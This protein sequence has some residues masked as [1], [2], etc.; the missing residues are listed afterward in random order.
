MF[1]DFTTTARNAP[2]LPELQLAVAATYEQEK[3]WA[4]AIAQYDNWLA[5]NPKHALL[6]RAEY[7]RAWDTAQAGLK[8]NALAAF[9]RF[10]ADFQT[11]EYAPLAQWWVASYYYSAGEMTEAERNYK[12][13]FQ[14]TNWPPS[15]LAYQSRMMA[16]RAAVRRQGWNQV[17]DY[18]PGL[19]NNT[20][21]PSP[22]LREQALFEYGQSLMQWT[23][24]GETNKLANCEEATRCFG[25]VCDEY[26]TN[27]LAVRAWIEKA[28]C[29][30]Q[31]ALARQNYDSLTNA[32]NAYQ[33]AFDSPQADVDLRSE[34]KLGQAI[35]LGKW[36]DQ[37]TG[38]ARTALLKQALSNCLDVVYVGDGE[39]L[40]PSLRQKAA[41]KAFD[42]ADALQAWSQAVNI[43]MRLTNSVWPLTDPSMQ[44]RVTNAF[45]NLRR[46]KE[47]R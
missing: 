38:E 47:N 1:L 39:R 30:L 27:R 8:T 4:E 11:N 37:K 32:L 24:P 43:Y 42:L 14:N 21:G 34:A 23:A 26:S 16:G 12:L 18:F 3:K 19:Y 44:K 22:D 15:E 28:N 13:L 33:R 5:G 31:W 9:V 36:A 20:N 45:E 7:Y 6:P 40:D 10:V 29:Y 35:T 41:E 2:L 46:E 25:R 17:P